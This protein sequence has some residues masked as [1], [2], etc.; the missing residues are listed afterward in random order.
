MENGVLLGCWKESGNVALCGIC[1][2]LWL[3]FLNWTSRLCC[4]LNSLCLGTNTGG[5]TEK[6][7]N[8]T[9]GNL[10]LKTEKEGKRHK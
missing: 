5:R 2:S 4:G 8:K 9:Q 6:H 1:G 3:R 7:T 10:R